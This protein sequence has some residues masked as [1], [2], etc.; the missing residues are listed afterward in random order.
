MRGCQRRGGPG[1]A[2]S[3]GPAGWTW[4]TRSGTSCIATQSSTAAV[5]SSAG[6]PDDTMLIY[7]G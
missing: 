4:P 3:W 2:Y 6:A 5:Q 1:R 7:K